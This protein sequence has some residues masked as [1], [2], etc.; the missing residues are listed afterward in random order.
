[1]RW[2]D[3]ITNSMDM[4]YARF[5]C[6]S[7]TPRACS[8][9]VHGVTRVV[10]DWATE[11]NWAETLYI[12]IE[13]ISQE[14]LSWGNYFFLFLWFCIYIRWWM[15]TTFIVVIISWCICQIIMLCVLSLYSV[16]CQLYLSK[17]ERKTYWSAFSICYVI[18]LFMKK[19][20]VGLKIW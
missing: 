9:A 17:T 20:L 11:M 10:H 12:K 13:S 3:G 7:P 1:M 6:P 8:A 18:Q 15:L 2:S 19:S 14:F 5:P 16:L 4:S